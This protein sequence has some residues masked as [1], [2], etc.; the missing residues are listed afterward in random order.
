[1]AEKLSWTELRRALAKRAGV[2]EKTAGAFLNAVQAQLLEAL[3]T[4]KQVKINGL[5]TFK[6]QAVAPR[7]SVNVTTGEEILIEGYNKLAFT[8]EAGVR[9]LVESSKVESEESNVESSPVIDPIQKLGAQAEEIVDILG[10][11]GQSPKEEPVAEPEPVVEEP[12]PVIE[13]PAPEPEPVFI[14][15]PT[16]VVEPEPEIIVQRP[17]EEKKKSHFWRDT[18]ICVIILLLLLAGGYFFLRQELSDII[19][20][21]MAPAETEEVIVGEPVLMVEEPA[22]VEEPA[23]EEPAEEPAPAAESAETAKIPKGKIPQEQILAEFLAASGET[24]TGTAEY[25]NLITVETMHEGSR[26]TW[27]SKRFYGKKVYWPYLY[28]A[29]RDVIDNPNNI[30]TGTPL[31]VP[32]LTKAQMDTTSTAFLQ[33]KQ[34]AEAACKR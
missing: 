29:N 28:D 11:L 7:K 2:S 3:K 33:L 9:E 5:G 26:L 14:P 1:M 12:E 15:E 24:V 32:K 19:R 20:S 30:D 8:P 16:P 17:K 10:D 6:V 18:L 22:V 4:D 21:F 13:E 27:M 34:E 23:A 25:P 31:R